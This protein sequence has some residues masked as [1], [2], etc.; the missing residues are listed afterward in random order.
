VWFW[1]EEHGPVFV[2]KSEV[3]VLV[4]ISQICPF[5][6]WQP[7][8]VWQT[9]RL[10][11]FTNVTW[12]A[13]RAITLTDPGSSSNCQATQAAQ[14]WAVLLCLQQWAVL[15]CLHTCHQL[16]AA[17]VTGMKGVQASWKQVQDGAVCF[18]ALSEQ[19]T[20]G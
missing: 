15:L 2:Q 4:Q 7:A 11:F 5:C 13:S 1:V 19:S 9:P 12:F 14:Q 10:C 16:Q 17:I 8:P 6:E 3:L 20:A 18:K